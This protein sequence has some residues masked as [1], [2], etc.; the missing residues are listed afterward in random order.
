MYTYTYIY[1][2][3]SNGLEYG[4]YCGEV[5][6]DFKIFTDTFTRNLVSVF[7]HIGNWDLSRNGVALCHW[8]FG[9]NPLE[10]R[11]NRKE[12]F[13]QGAYVFVTITLCID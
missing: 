6:M 8:G 12:A 10:H 4:Q 2:L 9:G 11:D 1:I 3:L 13:R 7:R 5:S